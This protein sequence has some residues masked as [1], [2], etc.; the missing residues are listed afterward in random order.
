MTRHRARLDRLVQTRPT[1]QPGQSLDEMRAEALRRLD[2]P[3]VPLTPREQQPNMRAVLVATR[4]R[5][6]QLGQDDG[7]WDRLAS[8]WGVTL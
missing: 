3:A 6:R 8:L 4:E 2:A 5:H 7:R 1:P